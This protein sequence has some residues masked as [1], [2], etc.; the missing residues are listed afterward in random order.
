MD[1]ELKHVNYTA[2]IELDSDTLKFLLEYWI[3]STRIESVIYQGRNYYERSNLWIDYQKEDRPEW[4]PD[5]ACEDDMGATEIGC[6]C[7]INTR[8]YDDVQ[9][10]IVKRERDW[11]AYYIEV[12]GDNAMKEYEICE[13]SEK[14][15]LKEWYY[16]L[17]DLCSNYD[18]SNIFVKMRNI[19]ILTLRNMRGYNVDHRGSNHCQIQLPW[20]EQIKIALPINLHDFFAALY[21]TKSHKW[22]KWYEL[23]SGFKLD[24][25]RNLIKLN[26]DHGS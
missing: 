22:D 15:T 25:N 1:I 19:E 10:E 20:L 24:L 14:V 23:Y 2:T 6:G 9:Y 17:Y 13:T 21:K 26:F 5:V 4:D 18:L 16:R 3:N 11:L 7:T 8:T 12:M